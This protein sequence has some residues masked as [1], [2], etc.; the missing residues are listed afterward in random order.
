MAKA[1]TSNAEINQLIVK[2]LQKLNK[3]VESLEKAIDK[4]KGAKP[5]VSKKAAPEKAKPGNRVKKK[6]SK[7]KAKTA[8]NVDSD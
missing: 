7:K 8:A 5:K 2:G 1:K 3:K 6:D 4:L